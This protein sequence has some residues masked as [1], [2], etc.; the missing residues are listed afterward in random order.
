MSGFSFA[1]ARP[2]ACVEAI[3][4]AGYERVLSPETIGRLAP[5]A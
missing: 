1:Q 2:H 5:A 3:A 4:G